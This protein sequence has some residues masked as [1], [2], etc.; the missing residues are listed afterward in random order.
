MSSKTFLEILKQIK[1]K[2]KTSQTQF[3]YIEIIFSI[4]KNI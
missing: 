1:N 3:Q 4:K 2:T